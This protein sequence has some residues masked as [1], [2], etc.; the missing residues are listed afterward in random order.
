[1]AEATE[2]RFHGRGG[3]G[4]VTCAKILAAA[5]RAASARACR[6]S[7]TTRA[8]APARRCAPTR[9][10]ATPRST[11]RNKV[12]EPDHLV[13]LDPTLL[14]ADVFAG[15]APGG[16]LLVNT[17][18]PLADAR[19]RS[20]GLRRRDRRRAPPSRGGTAS[21][22]RSV[23]IVNTTIA[24]RLREARSS[25]PR[26]CSRAPT[27]RLG[28][29]Q[30]LRGRARRRSTAVA[31]AGPAAEARRRAAPDAG[32]AQARA[33]AGRR[34]SPRTRA[35]R[36]TGAADRRLAQ[37]DAASTSST[38]RRATR[39]ARR[40]TTSSASCRR[41]RTTART[42]AA[43]DP[44]A[45]ARRCAGVCGRVC[46]APC[47]ERLQPARDRRRRRHPRPRALDRR[48]GHGRAPSTPPATAA[49]TRASGRG[50][51]RR[52]GRPRP[53][54][55]PS[56]GHGHRPTIFDGEPRA[57][58]R[59]AHRHPDLPPAARRARPRARAPCST[60][61]MEARCGVGARRRPTSRTARRL[62][63]TP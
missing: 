21:A 27:R 61:G 57:R 20:P 9:G 52:P 11:N 33:A 60:L 8:S 50:R 63:T 44:R 45:H 39:S 38:S 36:A 17:P 53:P 62:R 7:A 31:D 41:W 6:R 25:C 59:A 3:Q 51:R 35:A 46:P 58:R 54:P 34:R 24:G 42:R 14:G 13:V 16:S 5:L 1:M 28:F 4:G 32:A 18:E 49:T 2:I 19:W 30:R 29:L 15:L 55:T 43:R 37:P 26:T 22:A 40:A 12:Y 23:V 10:S 48:P 56:R 47:M